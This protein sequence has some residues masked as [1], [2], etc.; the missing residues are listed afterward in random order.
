MH[1]SFN[2]HMSKERME[3]FQREAT[4]MQQVNHANSNS[5]NVT[6][7]H[8]FTRLIWY[9][10]FGLHIQASNLKQDEADNLHAMQT[11]LHA[12]IWMVGCVALGL[13]LLVGGFLYG[14]FGLL[15]IVLLSGIILVAVSLPILLRSVSL[16]G[17]HYQVS[18]H[19]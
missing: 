19:R 4:V 8:S 10:L 18:S 5:D 15:P 9:L 6:G 3:Q 12:A 1:P 14:K 11:R 16:L 7:S 17:R 2:E 13:G